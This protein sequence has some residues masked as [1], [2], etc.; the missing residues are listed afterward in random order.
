[1]DVNRIWMGG[2]TLG[3]VALL[4]SCGWSPSNA[5]F[6]WPEPDEPLCV[7]EELNNI[8]SA[9][10]ESERLGS[11]LI[12]F[13]VS[14]GL[15]S[16][17]EE[18][19]L[20]AAGA[21][22]ASGSDVSGRVLITEVN[23]QGELDPGTLAYAELFPPLGS[24]DRFGAALAAADLFVGKSDRRGEELLVGA[25]GY[26]GD[27]GEVHIYSAV[28]GG[29]GQ[30]SL[31]VTLPSPAGPAGRFG[32]SIAAH[33]TSVDPEAPWIRTGI[34][35]E[36]I[37][38]GAPGLE[39]VFV[40]AVDPAGAL[41]LVQSL[42][43]PPISLGSEFGSVLSVADFNGDGT[44]DLAVSAPKIGALDNYGRVW[45][46]KGDPA[47]GG[48]GGP[49]GTIGVAIHGTALADAAGD[50]DSFGWS[51]SSGSL[52]SLDLSRAALVVGAPGYTTPGYSTDDGQ[53]CLFKFI[54]DTSTA[55]GLA[56]IT[57]HCEFALAGSANRYGAAVAV[58]NFNARD[59][60]GASS[61]PGALV[62]ELAVGSPG[63]NSSEGEV[64]LYHSTGEWVYFTSVASTLRGPGGS[65]VSGA[66]YGTTIAA[67]YGQPSPWEDL[68]IGFPNLH[69][70]GTEGYDQGGLEITRANGLSE[71]SN[72]PLLGSY[73]IS[74]VAV[75]GTPEIQ[76]IRDGGDN[77]N[78]VAQNKITIRLYPNGDTSLPACT[79][80]DEDGN[81]VNWTVVIPK[82]QGLELGPISCGD[83]SHSH[84]IGAEA[85]GHLGLAAQ[86]LSYD[87]LDIGQQTAF[88]LS[89]QKLDGTSWVERDFAIELSV[90]S[91][92]G[93]GTVSW[94]QEDLAWSAMRLAVSGSDSAC[95]FPD[96]P[97]TAISGV[98]CED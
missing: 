93:S 41:T 76:L 28:G 15:S 78:L 92:G 44:M 26:G 36:W 98:V 12:Q 94:Q 30:L 95:R 27:P 46:Y 14:D 31:D 42:A 11:A 5:S 62:Q 38:V 86:G 37:A 8:G 23:S 79:A 39:Q 3:V 80:V 54:D 49:L 70:T 72:D 81:T 77:L 97:L 25:P 6:T 7:T 69:N 89:T 90:D 63:A 34:H 71:C 68:L 61:T 51:L 65:G 88:N 50:V 74:T 73:E 52:N 40:Y 53:I 85:M 66:E 43:S 84:N 87:D 29:A 1:M 83:L 75:N 45:V 67:G 47:W 19:R 33:R 59:G 10:P 16:P 82:N 56:A 57:H 58:G 35:P 96:L 91:T 9:E 21:P 64:L 32:A 20:V 55:S 24:S 48:S 60:T 17:D 18:Y 22:G 2:L 4:A 13:G